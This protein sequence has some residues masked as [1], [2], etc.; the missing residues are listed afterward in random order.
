MHAFPAVFPQHAFSTSESLSEDFFV[1]ASSYNND[2]DA[3][4]TTNGGRTGGLPGY[5]K[6]QLVSYNNLFGAI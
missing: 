4:Q 6:T 3:G 2:M 1:R 5:A